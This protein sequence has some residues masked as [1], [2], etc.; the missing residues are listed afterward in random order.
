MAVAT[1]QEPRVE[2]EVLQGQA[3]NPHGAG[4]HTAQPEGSRSPGRAGPRP[5]AL[6]WDESETQVPP[7]QRLLRKRALGTRECLPG[8][9]AIANLYNSYLRGFGVLKIVRKEGSGLDMGVL[10]REGGVSLTAQE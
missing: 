1:E 8:G 3:S 2:A 4:A 10:R 7:C 5:P 6:P 9:Q